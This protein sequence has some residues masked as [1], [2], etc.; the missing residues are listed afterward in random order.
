MLSSKNS[1][2]VSELKTAYKNV[3]VERGRTVYITGNLGRLGVLENQNSGLL[4]SD[5]LR[6]HYEILHE[7][8]GPSGNLIFPT[9]SWGQVNSDELFDV[10]ETPSDYTFSEYL[11]TNLDVCRQQHPFSSVAAFGPR[12]EEIIGKQISRHAYGPNTPSEYM[13]N[14]DALHVSVGLPVN[15]TIS[16]VH[17][18]EY[19]AGVPYRYT[20]AFPK[21]IR[22]ENDIIDDEFYLF[23]VYKNLEYTRDRNKKIFSISEIKNSVKS[24]SLGRTGIE[25]ISL[26]LFVTHTIRA[27]QLDPFIWL[28]SKPKNFP[29]YT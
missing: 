22:F 7:L 15:L 5:I 9:H 26:G 12:K 28:S 4:K 29:W 10:Y 21:K 24:S 25:S 6:V 8:I 23:V 18:C 1:F 13:A 2:S 16:S 11:R 27:M 20:K 19:L 17:H 3:G 14:S